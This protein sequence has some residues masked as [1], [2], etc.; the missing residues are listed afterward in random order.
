MPSVLPHAVHASQAIVR[1]N[2]ELEQELWGGNLHNEGRRGVQA[3]AVV[4]RGAGLRC[5]HRYG[6]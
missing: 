3:R 5:M 6:G 1:S 4:V 2:R